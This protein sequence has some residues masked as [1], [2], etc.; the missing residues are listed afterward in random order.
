MNCEVVT[1]ETTAN[2]IKRYPISNANTSST[3]SASR[4]S[5]R[6]GRWTIRGSK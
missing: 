3:V 4:L 2:S 6:V 1:L 5:R